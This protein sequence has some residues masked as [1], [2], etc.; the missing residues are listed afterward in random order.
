M[1]GV[2]LGTL[3]ATRSAECL[4]LSEMATI[5]NTVQ[6]LYINEMYVIAMT[7][8]KVYVNPNFY[9]SLLRLLITD[10]WQCAKQRKAE[11]KR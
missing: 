11:I 6:I 8:A 10:T 3:L 9:A 5:K 4:R 1:H 2:L 7:C